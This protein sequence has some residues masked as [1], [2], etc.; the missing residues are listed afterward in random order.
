MRKYDLISGVI[1]LGLTIYI[2]IESVKLGIGKFQFPGAGFFPLLTGIVMGF[3]S[4]WLLLEGKK[5]DRLEEVKR[6]LWSAETKWKNIVLTLL[7]FVIYLI[8]LEKIGYLLSTF[9]LMLLLFNTMER[10]WGISILEATITVILS[11]IVFDVWLKCQLPIG[12]TK[13]FLK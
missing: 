9:I 12:I 3:L 13:V 11:Y 5:G 8:V 2:C 10:K 4:V 1:W 7:A 6:T